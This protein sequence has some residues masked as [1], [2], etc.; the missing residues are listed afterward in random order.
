ME[1]GE[2]QFG[3]TLLFIKAPESLFLLEEQI[4]KK[5]NAAARVIQKTFRKYFNN[6]ALLKQK[7][8][9]ADIL[10]TKKERREHSLNRQFFGDYIGLDD[11]P[12]IQRLV[13]KR[14]KIEFAQTVEKYDRKKFG[15]GGQD[16]SGLK[17]LKRALILTAKGIYIIGHQANKST[18]ALEEVISR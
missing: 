12:E 1:P 7:E 11:N 10:H 5:L 14:N 17:M 9:A 3:K 8:E 2:Y 16:K 6:S 18:G 13:G 15:F 4:E